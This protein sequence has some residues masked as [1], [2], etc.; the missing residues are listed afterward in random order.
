MPHVPLRLLT[1]VAEAV[2]ADR[3]ARAML[4]AGALGFTM[5]AAKGV[6]ARNRSSVK[7][8]AP[9]VRI[10]VLAGAATMKCLLDMLNEQW[11]PHY[12]MV[13]WE[14]AVDLSYS[15]QFLGRSD[16]ADDPAQ[17]PRE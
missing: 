9:N 2:L 13:A 3:L 10:E 17:K 16:D 6:G 15:E 11:F 5:T 4:D 8:S 7:A 14:S 1:V 12:P